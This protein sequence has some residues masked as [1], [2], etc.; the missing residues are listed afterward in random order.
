MKLSMYSIYDTIAE[1]FH[2]PFTSHND[3]D[4]S[5]AFTQAIDNNEAT[6]EDYVLY[7]VADWNDA[8]GEIT[9]CLPMKV[10]SGFD[11]KAEY[12]MAEHERNIREA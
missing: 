12:T 4:A 8:T 9:A 3:A 7:R 6:K 10:M 11:I 1:V 5:R 2:K